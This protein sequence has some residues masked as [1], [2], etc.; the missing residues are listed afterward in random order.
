[1][2]LIH[3]I[4]M[5]SLCLGLLLVP[6]GA[7]GGKIS[8]FKG[9][10]NEDLD[11]ALIERLTDQGHEVTEFLPGGIEEAEQL[12]E[13]A[14]KDLVIISETIGSVQVTDTQAAGGAFTLRTL[15]KPIISFEPYHWDES[16]WTAPVQFEDFGNTG[17]PEVAE[18]SL[19]ELLDTLHVK[20]PGHPM[21]AGFSGAVK[22]Y[23]EKFSFNFATP[24]AGTRIVATVD[25]AGKYATHFEIPKGTKLEDESVTPEK[26]IG[27]FLA[28]GSGIVDDPPGQLTK[29]EFLSE[30]G[31]AML[32]ASI[33]Y[34]LTGGGGGGGAPSAGPVK[35][36][37][38]VK[39]SDPGNPADESQGYGK[40]DKEFYISKFEVT[41]AEY[42]AF[43]NAVA[44]S[45]DFGL[46]N[47]SMEIDQN[48]NDGSYTYEAHEDR[49][50]R[51]IRWLEAVDGMRFCNWLHNGAS[52]GGDTEDGAYTFSD[53]N[54]PG[55][56]NPG[57]KFF[58][59]N[60]DEW[61]KAAYFDPTKNQG[62]GG[63]WYH[64]VRADDVVSGPP[65]GDKTTANFDA[66]VRDD[67]EVS[68]VGAYVM[69]T[70]YYG[71]H[72]QTAN[73]WEWLEPSPDAPDQSRRRSG[74]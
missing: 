62:K 54:T 6:T 38:F 73:V 25:A 50:N 33:D 12:A 41:V 20:E 19:R 3:G 71:T 66:V 31:L 68:D 9:T 28:Q 10:S 42:A 52:D 23:A 48:G 11:A 43:L 49:G 7:F 69:A 58:V 60:E 55:P 14:D 45:D 67:G 35:G 36:T 18:E 51:P 40:V 74:S 2:K 72:D 27:I 5:P 53:P 46:Y 30:Q 26:R 61:F 29:L 57:A 17:R 8:Y 70:S 15:A 59:P 16:F 37:N 21:A 56:R 65:P 64:A 4:W 13:A 24:P 44:R 47:P 34:A 63:Y 1:M 22:V 39:V 32:D